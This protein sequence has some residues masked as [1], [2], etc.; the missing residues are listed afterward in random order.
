MYV[1]TYVRTYGTLSCRAERMRML[2]ACEAPVVTVHALSTTC[3]RHHMR[4][5]GSAACSSSTTSTLSWNRT[6]MDRHAR[7]AA[8]RLSNKLLLDTHSHSSCVIIRNHAP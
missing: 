7:A 3:M 6:V 4:H 2:L 1:R 8:E 5:I